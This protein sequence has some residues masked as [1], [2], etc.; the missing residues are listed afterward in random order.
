MSEQTFKVGDKVVHNDRGTV[1]VTYGPYTNPIGGTNYVIQLSNGRET[2]VLSQTLT[3]LVP[4][5]TVGDKVTSTAAFSGAVAELVAGP[6]ASNFG[7]FWV[8]Q[9]ANGAHRSV[10][11]RT[12][13]KAPA[14][15]TALV[16]V[17]TRV[18]ID[19]AAFAQQDHGRTGVVTSNTETWRAGDDD[20]HPYIVEFDGGDDSIHVAELTLVDEP[21]D[22]FTHNGIVY[23]FSAE[24]EDFE[25]DVWRFARV[26]GEIMGDYGHRRGLI[27]QYSYDIARAVNVW[28]PFRK[29]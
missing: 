13:T 15:A 25:G 28:G 16:P 17:G 27:N 14:P 26:D 21:A 8:A 22:T 23:D 6:F 24:Y 4:V 9:G 12:L 11:E 19:R 3:A 20:S 2:P 1:E 7:A 10:R 29:I 18:R 5:F